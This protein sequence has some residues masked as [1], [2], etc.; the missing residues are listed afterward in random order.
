MRPF[1]EPIYVTRP[2]LPPLDVYA[3]ALREIWDRRRLTNRGPVLE[4]F[5]AH[6][7]RL[8]GGRAVSVLSNG[9]AA[10]ELGLQALDLSGEV[11]TTPFTFAATIN[12]AVRLGLKPVFADVE[13]AHLTVDP[14]AVEAAITPATTAILAVHMFGSPCQLQP[15]ADIADRH[16]LRLVYDAAHA[17]GVTA[18]GRSMAAFGDLVM[19]SFHATKPFHAVEGGALVF[20]DAALKAAVDALANHGLQPDG[21]VLA[22]GA[23]AKMSEL[24]A[25]MGELMLDRFPSTVAH[26]RAVEDVYRARLSTVPGVRFLDPPQPGVVSN[27]AFMPVLIDAAAFGM[28]RDALYEALAAHNVFTRRYFYPLVSEMSAYSRFARADPLERARRAAQEILA[29][30]TYADLAL[31]DVHRICDLVTF[32]QRTGLPARFAG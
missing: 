2:D 20:G 27:H 22:P 28:P 16:G 14:A 12:A 21:D 24:H 7:G 1:E 3:A 26:G 13:P 19:F 8:L 30:P 9:A 32:I 5:E 23:N 17:F 29:L 31:G 4:R 15:L 25:L 6:L 11:V 18:G 10:L